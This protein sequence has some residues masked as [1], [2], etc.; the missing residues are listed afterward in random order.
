MAKAKCKEAGKELS[1][2]IE[3]LEQTLSASRSKMHLIGHSLGGQ[4]CQQSVPVN[5]LTDRL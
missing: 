2:F 4:V 5:F 1:S 3:R